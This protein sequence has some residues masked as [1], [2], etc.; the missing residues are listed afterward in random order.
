MAKRQSASFGALAARG[1]LACRMRARRSCL[2]VPGSSPR[3]LAKASGLPA[4]EVVIDLEDAVA[5]PAKDDARASVVS[6]LA[7]GQ[8]EGRTVAVRVNGL[9]TPWCQRDIVAL[10]DGPAAG[11]VTT[12]VVPKVQAPEDIAWVARLLDMIGA[13]AR[14]IRLQALIETA[15]GLGQAGCIGQAGPRL[16][17]LIL[18]YADLRASLGRPASAEEPPD[19]WSFAQEAVLV[20]ARAAG[21]QAIDGPHLRA[22]DAAGLSAWASHARA[23]GYDGK[24]AIH[25][26]QLDTLNATFS[27]TPEEIERARG[28]ISA[29]EMAEADAGRG[30]VTLDGEMIDEALRK[31]ALE[32]LARARAA[33]LASVSVSA[34]G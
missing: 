29:L 4:D 18:G 14:A 1:R 33:G 34:A 24:W 32:V 23:L 19:R 28:I 10:A 27:P 2:S 26:S 3:M 15:A 21:L 12:L 11:A 20:A 17:A 30:V 6:F 7:S 25:P 22:D 13:G 5:A 8:M 16:E 31:Q 9:D